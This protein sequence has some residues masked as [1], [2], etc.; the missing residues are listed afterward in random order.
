MLGLHF[1]NCNKFGLSVSFDNCNLSHSSFY[2]L[3]LKMTTFKNSNFHEVDFTECDLTGSVFDSCDFMKATFEN[4]IIEKADFRTSFNYSIDP[5]KNR[6][7]KAI[8]SL[9]GIAG[10]LDK[11]DIEID[12]KD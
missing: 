9:T 12:T 2:Q 7:K 6:I 11:Y 5:E 3:K 10:L 1:E 4:S 8:F